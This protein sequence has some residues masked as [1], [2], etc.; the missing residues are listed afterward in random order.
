MAPGGEK[1]KWNPNQ[2]AGTKARQTASCA[3]SKSCEARADEVSR[4]RVR[5]RVMSTHAQGAGARSAQSAAAE[6]RLT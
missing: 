4:V 3:H 1:A 6:K 5:V 2:T